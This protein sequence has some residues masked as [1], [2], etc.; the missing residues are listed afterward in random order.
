MKKKEELE[1][2]NRVNQQRLLD[3][4]DCLYRREDIENNLNNMPNCYRKKGEEVHKSAE[5]NTKAFKKELK[6][7]LKVKTLV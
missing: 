1:E 2:N 3:N 4:T 7:F 6:D 5:E